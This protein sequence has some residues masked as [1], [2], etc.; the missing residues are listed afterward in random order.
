MPDTLF[1]RLGQHPEQ[2]LSWWRSEQ[3]E[4][5]QYGSLQD[6]AMA[7]AGARVVVLAPA[8]EMLCT[9]VEVSAIPAG[10]L[11]QALPYALEEQLAADVDEMHFAMGKRDAAGYLPVIAV[12]RS[13]M[14]RWQ[15]L[16]QQADLHPHQMVN[17]AQMLPWQEGHWSLLLEDG[18]ALLRRFAHD[19][20]VL[21]LAQ[22]DAWLALAW[23]DPDTRQEETTLLVFDA[24]G[25]REALPFTPPVTMQLEQRDC[26]EALPL[27][28]QGSALNLLSGEFSRHEQLGRLWRPWRGVAAMLLAWLVL[29]SGMAVSD[30]YALSAEDERLYQAIENTYRETFPQAVNVVNP[31]VQ[32]ERHLEGLKAGGAQ[33]VFIVLLAESGPLLKTIDT[34]QVRNL[35]YR[36][37][38]LEYELE[39]TAL[40]ALDELKGKLEQVGLEVEIRTATTRDTRVEARLAVRRGRV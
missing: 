8:S 5:T 16:L 3:T 35:R 10:K 21:P 13:Q 14:L 19:G 12:E 33:S 24:R 11:R 29:Q 25:N 40:A 27:L 36:Q 31:R 30:Y 37:G 20:L 18:Q 22:L 38:E 34:L 23:A 6:A 17:E 15:E 4:H 32:M 28:L 9:Q 1:L 2:Q 26:P 7:A 39:L